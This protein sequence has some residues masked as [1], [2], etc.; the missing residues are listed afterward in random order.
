MREMHGSINT[1]TP[2]GRSNFIH[3]TA[4]RGFV[5]VSRAIPHTCIGITVQEET[6]DL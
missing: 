5:I 6:D 2:A 3:C 4:G 1:S